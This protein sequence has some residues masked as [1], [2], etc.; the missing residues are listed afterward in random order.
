[1][2]IEDYQ[3]CNLCPR[4]CGADRTQGETGVCGESAE[5]RVA[6]IGPHHGEEPSFSGTHGSG[7]IF[8]SGCSCH[9]C[10]CQNFQISGEHV[11]AVRSMDELERQAAAL[12]D[13]GVHNLNFVTPDHFWPHIRALCRRLRER[14]YSQPFLFNSSGYELPERV[15]EY[16]EWMD[17][18]MPDFKFADAALAEECMGDPR[19]SEYALDAITRMVEEKGFLYP[20]DPTGETPAREGVLVRHLVL[21][22]HVENSLQVLRILHDRFGP[23]IPLSVMSQFRPTAHCAEHAPLNRLLNAEEYRAVADRVRELEFEHVYLQELRNTSDFMP[24]FAR[25]SPFEGNAC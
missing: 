16:A 6:S 21:P 9:C 5:C 17:I 12:L 18:F 15:P 13:R 8:F 4:R 22:G 2:E 19:Y 11:G 7:T 25:P 24:D 23:K 3:D 1:M 14:E 20:W 10:F